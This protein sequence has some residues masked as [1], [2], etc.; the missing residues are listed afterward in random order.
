MHSLGDMLLAMCFPGLLGVFCLWHAWRDTEWF[1]Q[2]SQADFWVRLL[3]RK[4]ARWFYVA[5]GIF[6]L[7]VSLIGAWRHAS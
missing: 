6:I 1:F 4:G 7:L 3:G 2:N 5:L